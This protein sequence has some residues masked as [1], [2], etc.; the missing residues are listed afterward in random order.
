MTTDVD[1]DINRDSQR[2]RE[3]ERS[4]FKA[5]AAVFCNLISKTDTPPLLPY[6]IGHI[7]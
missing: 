2:H 6:S 3:N 5:E 4:K 1:I 7:N